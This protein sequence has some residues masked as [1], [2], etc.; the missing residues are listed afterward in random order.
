[1]FALAENNKRKDKYGL[2]FTS[3][4]MT[5]PLRICM[6]NICNSNLSQTLNEFLAMKRKLYVFSVS[7]RPVKRD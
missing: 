2:D 5:S 1:M 6:M 3:S 4:I 7:R